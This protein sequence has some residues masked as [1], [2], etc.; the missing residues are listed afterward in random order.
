M[1]QRNPNDEGR[2]LG[3]AMQWETIFGFVTVLLAAIFGVYLAC[4]GGYALAIGSQP[5]QV[6]ALLKLILCLLIW[7]TVKPLITR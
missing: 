6:I 4:S 3:E 1:T 2:A 5:Q 7:H